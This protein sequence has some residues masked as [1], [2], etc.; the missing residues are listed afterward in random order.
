[1]ETMRSLLSDAKWMDRSSAAERCTDGRTG[2][3]ALSTGEPEFRPHH[4]N[5]EPLIR[6]LKLCV[7]QQLSKASSVTTSASRITEESLCLGNLVCW[8]NASL[9]S[10]CLFTAGRRGKRPSLES[11]RIEIIFWGDVGR[12]TIPPGQMS[13]PTALK[14]WM[15]TANQPAWRTWCKKDQVKEKYCFRTRVMKN[16]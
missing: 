8:S 4:D 9:K 13:P 16:G 11:L 14:T 7:L 2:R 12:S 1:M 15:T 6:L 10:T 5:S 3:L